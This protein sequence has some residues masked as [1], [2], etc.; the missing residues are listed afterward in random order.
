MDASPLKPADMRPRSCI[1][2]QLRAVRY[3]NRL[4]AR[5]RWIGA[6]R[7]INGVW[8]KLAKVKNAVLR[9]VGI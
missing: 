3:P 6:G 8:K 4:Y 7:T 5:S 1:N 9:G 2:Q